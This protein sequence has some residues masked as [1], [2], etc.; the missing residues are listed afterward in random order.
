MERG[1]EFLIDSREKPKFVSLVKGKGIDFRVTAL[2]ADIVL[3]RNTKPA[4]EV[5]GIER[6]A[7]NDLVQSI[8]SKRI[9]EQV[10]RLKQL[11]EIPFLFISGS[12]DELQWKFKQQLNMQINPNVVY[13]TIASLTVR[14]RINVMWFPDDKT[15]I[16]VAH[17]MCT[18]ISEGKWGEERTLAAKY[19]MY[20][21]QKMLQRTV[22]GLTRSK[23]KRLFDRFKTLKGVCLADIEQLKSVEGIGPETAQLIY[24]LMNR[25]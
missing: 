15:L 1:W 7:I 10:K 18:K 6:K 4:S 8:Q 20:D 11:H 23:A 22:P 17:R 3:R 9:F 21:P 14:E 19:E 25:D 2:N 5:V 12:L 13:G 16:E 24:N